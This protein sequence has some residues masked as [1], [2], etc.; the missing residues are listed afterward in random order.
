MIQNKRY[1]LHGSGI[2]TTIV[3]P[4]LVTEQENIIC[5][6]VT[7]KRL[8][9]HYREVQILLSVAGVIVP[10]ATINDDGEVKFYPKEMEEYIN[11]SM[12]GVRDRLIW[13]Q[14]PTH[15]E[16][17]QFYKDTVPDLFRGEVQCIK[18]LLVPKT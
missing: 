16:L 14:N 11:D 1:Q 13:E 15:R 10:L 18:A 3:S 2:K 9:K 8:L 12:V 6:A 4:L 5:A 17:F 7:A